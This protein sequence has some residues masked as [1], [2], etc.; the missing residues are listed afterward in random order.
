MQIF[1][2]IQEGRFGQQGSKAGRSKFT[3]GQ[4]QKRST[5]AGKSKVRIYS[6]IMTAL[7]KGHFGQAFSTKGSDR[8]YVITKAKW[9]KDKDQRVGDKVAKGFSPGTIPS[10]FNTVKG[11]ASR[12]MAKH[13]KSKAKEFKQ[14]KR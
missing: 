14:G 6:T 9:G 3:S 7:K 12:T 13:G 4:G 2:I 5:K 10:S 1:E 8:L 11:Y